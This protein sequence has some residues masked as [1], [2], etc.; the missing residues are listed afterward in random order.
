VEKKI[1]THCLGTIIIHMG[2]VTSIS[3]AVFAHGQVILQYDDDVILRQQLEE[4]SGWLH[5]EQQEKFES[6]RHR[7]LQYR[8]PGDDCAFLLIRLCHQDKFIQIPIILPI[9]QTNVSRWILQQVIYV[10]RT[11]D[12]SYEPFQCY[13]KPL[14]E[15]LTKTIY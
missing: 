4:V 12:S 3:L 14:G 13:L 2:L 1:G 10:L 15:Y 7:K 11:D 6:C 5:S 8:K 9:Q